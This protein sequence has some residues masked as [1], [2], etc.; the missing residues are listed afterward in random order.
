MKYPSRE[1]ETELMN[2]LT[3]NGIEEHDILSHLLGWMSSDETCHALEDLCD[4]C[5]IDYD[6]LEEG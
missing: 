1:R 3:E 5:D 2:L 6:D 4:D